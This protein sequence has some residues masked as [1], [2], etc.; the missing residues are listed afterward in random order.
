MSKETSV[1][2]YQARVGL[3]KH[4]GNVESTDELLALCRI[5]GSKTVL[6]V[7]CGVGATAC[8]IAKR[9][10]CHIVGVDIS[11]GM[12][13]WAIE[14]AR[15]EG[16]E[17]L[18]EFRVAD[19]QDLP[20][21]DDTFDIVMT[22]S[23][24]VLPPDK[25]RAVSEYARVT[26]PAGYVGLNETTWLKT[27]VPP[28]LADYIKQDMRMNAEVQTKDGWVDLLQGAGLEIVSAEANAIDMGGEVK[29]M[30]KRY[31]CRGM[32]LVWSRILILYLRDPGYRAFVKETV[33]QSGPAPKDLVE[34]VGY[35]IYVGQKRS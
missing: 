32:I 19:A 27:P 14:R 26:R 16:L 20:F 9:Y 6:D 2:D 23:V 29:G 7:G 31:G 3:T 25:Q 21:E 4:L 33:S 22:E 34:Y 10:G 12:I 17:A 13:E 8:Y 5:D 30:I 18:T 24:T 28:E 35:G 1:F 11:E 15:K